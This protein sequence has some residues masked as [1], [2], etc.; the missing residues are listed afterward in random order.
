MAQRKHAM[1]RNCAHTKTICITI[2]LGWCLWG[3]RLP[4]SAGTYT[5]S[6]HGNSSTGVS[7]KGL[8][9]V[10]TRNYATGNCAHCH[11]Q[12]AS[13]KN[14]EPTPN[15]GPDNYLQA[16]TEQDLCLYCHNAN[17]TSY[18]QSSGTPDDIETAVTTKTYKH[19]PT[20]SDTAHNNN[21]TLTDIK[22]NKHVEC[23]D[24]HNP[25]TA[26]KTVHSQGLPAGNIIG[27][28][29]PLTG[30]TGAAQ[31]YSG[32]STNWSQPSQGS[33]SLQTAVKEY[34]ICFKCHSGSV[35]DPAVW[36]GTAG[37]GEWTD[38]ALE[39]NPNNQSSHPVISPLPAS[40]PGANGSSR[41]T[42]A[43][44]INGW[45]PGDTMYCSDCHEGDT[46]AGP[47]GSQYKWMLAGTYKA[48]PFIAAASNGANSGTYRLVTSF[49]ST[50]GVDT[51]FC[52]NCHPN[53]KNQNTAH[54]QIQ[55]H[56][57]AYKPYCVDC[58]IRVPHGGKVSRLIAA[59]NHSSFT[60]MPARYTANGEGQ[61]TKGT[62]A[63][64]TKKFSKNSPLSYNF[65]DCYS[66]ACG[67]RHSNSSY[68]DEA[69]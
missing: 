4:A 25:H 52:W 27:T 14:G 54:S 56:T 10:T 55:H 50:N 9:D 2:L 53:D 24:C 65:A 36:S 16:A 17:A 35:G 23:T 68:G 57:S 42:A 59:D 62:S 3:T 13:L 28:D 61:N 6:A 43:Q 51:C 60:N 44:L 40:D 8:N 58:H 32:A 63:P 39:F 46:A 21:E 45:S 7:R 64:M 12:H 47:H 67:G 30:A 66:T 31:G 15:G 1:P 26:D 34:Q 33:Y 48:W 18:N 5:S 38:V 29:S 19:D 49:G 41:L 11:E 22:N 20:I 69:W 37:S